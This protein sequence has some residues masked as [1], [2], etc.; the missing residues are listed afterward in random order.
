MAFHL[1]LSAAI[2]T[3]ITTVTLTEIQQ[4]SNRAFESCLSL[5]WESK[6]DVLLSDWL[7]WGFVYVSFRGMMQDDKEI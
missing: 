3:V 6:H 2:T 4:Q 7:P 1:Q 5:I